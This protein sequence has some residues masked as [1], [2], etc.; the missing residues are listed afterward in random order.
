MRASK[1]ACYSH[2]YAE[3]RATIAV[4]LAGVAVAALAIIFAEATGKGTSEALFPGRTI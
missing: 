2:S 1:K 3:R 4:P